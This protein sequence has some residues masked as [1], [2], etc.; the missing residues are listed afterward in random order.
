[1]HKS[2]LLKEAIDGLDI[3]EGGI[4]LDA[5]VGG[6]GH[7]EYVCSKFKSKVK[8]IGIDADLASVKKS[9]E[10]LKSLDCDHDI[11]LGN[12]SDIDLLINTIGVSRVD[13]ILAD[14]GLNTYQLEK[15]GRG[16][17]FK[18]DE[19]LV[20]TFNEEI[21]PEDLT[22]QTIVN[23]WSEE[24][25]SDIIYGYGE[26][27]YAKRIAKKIVEERKLK[28]IMTTFDLVEVISRAVPKEYRYRKIHFAT[29]TFQALRIAVND[30]L[31]RLETFLNKSFEILKQN[32]RMAI[33][34]FHSLEDRIVKRFFRKLKDEESAILI[35]KK[36][37]VP[38]SEEVRNNPKSRSA[39]LR[40]IQKIKA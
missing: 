34:T 22:A 12:F 5:T 35:N 15:S 16:F 27:R 32:G 24:S 10:R 7:S 28:K 8:I 36:P 21:E 39:K 26:E 38:S 23:D 31:R 11:L 13:N 30:E 9:E 25:L 1:M 33:I 20:M 4:F 14:L 40:I 29:K 2:V 19:P 17:T 6:G 18:K 3:K 37:V